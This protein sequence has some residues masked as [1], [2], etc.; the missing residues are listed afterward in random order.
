MQCDGRASILQC[1][2]CQCAN[3]PNGTL[4]A[5]KQIADC[6]PERTVHLPKCF[7]PDLISRSYHA[8][9]DLHKLAQLIELLGLIWRSAWRTPLS[10]DALKKQRR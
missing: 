10:S 4:L 2:C 3:N 5:V 8:L 9:D 6:L 7:R 1:R